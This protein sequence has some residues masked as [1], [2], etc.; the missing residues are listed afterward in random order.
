MPRRE[1]ML[2]KDLL[3]ANAKIFRSQGQSLDKFAKKT[4][5]VRISVAAYVLNFKI[6]QLVILQSHSCV[7][8]VI[9]STYC[10]IPFKFEVL[11]FKSGCIMV[12]VCVISGDQ[13]DLYL[14]R[15]A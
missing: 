8:L 3:I 5:K 4:V 7:V 13:R 1:G 10:H 12:C 11:Y 9:E 15:V 14:I 2:R 6:L